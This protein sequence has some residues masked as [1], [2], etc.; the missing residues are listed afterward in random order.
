MYPRYIQQA[1]EGAKYHENL[2]FSFAHPRMHKYNQS[3]FHLRAYFWELWSVWDYILQQVNS[4][5]LKLDPGRVRRDL[6]E[7]LK[8]KCPN[9]KYLKDLEEIQENDRLIRIKLIRDYAHKWQIDPYLIDYHGS[10]VNVICLNNLDAKD[11]KLPR[12]INI[13]RNDLWFMENVV[14]TLSEKGFFKGKKS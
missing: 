8:R 11:K 7:K 13:D 6:L 12:Q 1:L 2:A 14:K 10:I 4:E 5:T 3:A 9:Y